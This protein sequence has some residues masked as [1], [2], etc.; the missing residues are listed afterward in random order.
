[1]KFP[2]G[3]AIAGVVVVLATILLATISRWDKVMKVS[4]SFEVK[5]SWI[6]SWF[7]QMHSG[8]FLTPIFFVIHVIFVLFQCFKKDW[9]SIK[10]AIMCSPL[11]QKKLLRITK[12]TYCIWTKHFLYQVFCFIKALKYSSVSTSGFSLILKYKRSNHVT[13]KHLASGEAFILPV[14][15]CANDIHTRLV[16]RCYTLTPE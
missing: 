2:L 9:H 13:S 1:M 16:W 7:I 6:R 12:T 15:H 3:P 10:W 5:W 4:S 14:W 11:Q 8:S